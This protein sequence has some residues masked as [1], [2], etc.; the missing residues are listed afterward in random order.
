MK[1]SMVANLPQLAD[2]II[3]LS[4]IGVIVLSVITWRQNTAI[5]EL[6]ANKNK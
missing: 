4:F 2:F 3:A 6:K 1:K 5:K